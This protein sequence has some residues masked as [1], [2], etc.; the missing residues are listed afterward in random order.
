[1]NYWKALA[2]SALLVPTMAIAQQAEEMEE[3]EFLTSLDVEHVLVGNLLG[4]PV[5][6]QVTAVHEEEADAPA[7][8]A[9]PEGEE[10]IGTVDDM[11]VNLDGEIVGIVVGV[12]GFLGIGERDVGLSWE[13]I[14][15]QRDPENPD[16]YIV[17]TGLDRQLL[18]EAPE[19]E[20][21]RDGIL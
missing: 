11:I 10:V 9:T 8:P 12:G 15:V 7:Q 4:S 19:L 16:A 2:M 13:A 17:R 21:G 5:H 1:M 3:V 20:H 18:E 14:E 6:G